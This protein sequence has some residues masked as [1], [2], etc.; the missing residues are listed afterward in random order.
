MPLFFFFMEC[1]SPAQSPFLL[2]YYH[3]LFTIL[4]VLEFFLRYLV[5]LGFTFKCK[6][7]AQ[8]LIGKL[9]VC[10]ESLLPMSKNRG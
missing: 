1:F 10:G 2:G 9:K 8:K 6:R 4:S 3:A 5:T 7:G